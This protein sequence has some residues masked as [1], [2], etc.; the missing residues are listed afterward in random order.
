MLHLAEPTAADWFDRIEEHLDTIL[1]DHTHLEKRAASTAMSMIF[2]YTG[3]RRLAR[4][5]GDIV[6]E[7]MEHFTRMLDLLEERQIPFE[8]LHP[9]PYARELV[10][11]V[12]S[13][14]PHTLLD[15]LLVA[16]LIEAR[17]CERFRL[18]AERVDDAPLAEFYAELFESEARHY[19]VYVDLAH[20]YFEREEVVS[21]LDE[22]ARCE[23]R[24]L[25]ASGDA[26]RLHSW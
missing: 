1:V 8:R 5:L 21:R 19:T 13:E 16:A 14:E 22:L 15:K 25:R 9:A 12:R 20:R 10:A 4:V 7:E 24:A 3:R 2:R 23:V 11:E 18:L 17:S 26:P 6:A